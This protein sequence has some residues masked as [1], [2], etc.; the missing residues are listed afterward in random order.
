M[1]KKLLIKLFRYLRP[2]WKHFGVVLG[3]IFASQAFG[4][5]A[6]YLFAKMFDAKTFGDAMIYVIASFLLW[7]IVAT[8][9]STMR[10]YWETKHIV[11]DTD[12]HLNHT[13]LKKLLGLSIGQHRNQHSGVKQHVI[14]QG[15]NSIDQLV[16]MILFDVAPS[17]IQT[18]TTIILVLVVS[19]VVGAWI[20]AITAVFMYFSIKRNYK[21]KPKILTW[22]DKNKDQSKMV[23]EVY[24]NVPLVILEAQEE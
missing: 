4:L 16:Q 20:T 18:V 22:L 21:Y 11:F 12:I 7:F 13:S 5:L 2:Y 15:Q 14:T 19:P 6:P 10:S 17:V 8:V 9:I 1:N 24:R 3:L 23:S